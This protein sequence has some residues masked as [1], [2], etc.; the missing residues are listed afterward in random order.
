M[1]KHP[2][3][4]S[5]QI[6]YSSQQI[7]RTGY[8]KDRSFLSIYRSKS[9][10]INYI[11][12]N[13]YLPKPFRFSFRFIYILAAVLLEI[14]VLFLREP[15]NLTLTNMIPKV[16]HRTNASSITLHANATHAKSMH[17]VAK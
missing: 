1:N 8:A 13:L 10:K 16:L 6:R 7:Q 5:L 14:H 3:Y 11:R 17:L 15:G 12:R 2:F 4:K 9:Q